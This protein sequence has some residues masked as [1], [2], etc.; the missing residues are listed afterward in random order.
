MHNNYTKAENKRPIT[1]IS[2]KCKYHS[3]IIVKWRKLPQPATFLNVSTMLSLHGYCIQNITWIWK[4]SIRKKTRHYVNAKCT[5]LSLIP[6]SYTQKTPCFKVLVFTLRSI[7]GHIRGYL[8]SVRADIY[9]YICVC[10]ERKYKGN[11]NDT[12]MMKMS[13]YSFQFALMRHFIIGD[14]IDCTAFSV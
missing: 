14:K 13:M 10:K 8:D 12:Q 3:I 9:I 11:K 7:Q 2:R 6:H 4:E 5:M 1:K